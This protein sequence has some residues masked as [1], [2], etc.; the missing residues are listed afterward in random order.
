MDHET[1]I[2]GDEIPLGIGVDDTDIFLLNDE[3][4]KVGYNEVGEIVVRSRYLSSGYW[5]RPELNDAKFK[6]D[7]HE[8]DQ[9]S[10]Y[11]GD[12]GLMLPDGCLIH[13]GRKDFRVKIRG[14]GVETAEV[15]KVL[16]GHTAVKDCIVVDRRGDS[17]EQNSLLVYFVGPL[18]N[19]VVRRIL[20]DRFRTMVPSVFVS[21][22]TDAQRQSGSST[23]PE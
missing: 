6:A 20:L 4:G 19:A 12:L 16:K 13:K 2:N 15:E 7:P 11:T 21:D 9:R 18:P 1:Q 5:L 17:G 22:D 10:Y 8:A 23:L 14:Y 3:G